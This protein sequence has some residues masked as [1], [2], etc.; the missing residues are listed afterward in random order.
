MRVSTGVQRHPERE[1]DRLVSLQ[2]AY[3]EDSLE[4]YSGLVPMLAYT[5]PSARVRRLRS[6]DD[7]AF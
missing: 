3:D 4:T 1:G 6:F 7:D 2:Y 5:T